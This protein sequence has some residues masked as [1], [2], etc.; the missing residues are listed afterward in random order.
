MTFSNFTLINLSNLLTTTESLR[1]RSQI[2]RIA[3][4]E[5]INFYLPWNHKKTYGFL[6]RGTKVNSHKF[7]QYW[8]RNSTKVPEL[9]TLL[10]MLCTVTLVTLVKLYSKFVFTFPDH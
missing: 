6:S 8:E 10:N 1:H 5:L 7:A 4:S 9:F 3:I 2:S